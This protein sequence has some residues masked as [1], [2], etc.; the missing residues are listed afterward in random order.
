MSDTEIADI[1][2][3]EESE[4]VEEEFP[5]DE[6]PEEELEKEEVED[7]LDE[8]ELP[9]DEFEDADEP[10][11]ESS[12]E[13]VMKIVQ[14]ALV[15]VGELLMAA[16]RVL[17]KKNGSVPEAPEPIADIPLPG[18]LQGGSFTTEQMPAPS[19]LLE[20]NPNSVP[21][22]QVLAEH[23]VMS[24][25]LTDAFN[26]WMPQVGAMVKTAVA[27]EVKKAVAGLLKNTNSAPVQIKE[28]SP[29]IIK[30]RKENTQ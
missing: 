22:Q 5:E 4:L 18:K 11:P 24:K 28:V 30:V 10:M 20:I 9:E 14:S 12:T 25:D 29:R 19:V 2:K 7:E 17:A 26:A 13:E 27:E 1:D 6:I 23:A 21:A 3:A 16:E 8:E 15:D